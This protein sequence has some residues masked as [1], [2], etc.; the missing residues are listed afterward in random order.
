MKT[1]LTKLKSSF[2][3]FSILA[4]HL[5]WAKPVAQVVEISGQVFAITEDGKTRS[6]KLNEHL[7]EKN[8]VMVEEGS[9]IT[10][11]DY[12]DATYHLIGGSHLKFFD[13]S[14]QLK[15]GKTWIQSKN[16]RHK[17]IVTTANGLIEFNKSEFITTFSHA[18][19]RSQVLVVNGDVEVSNI[20]EKNMKQVVS[21][22]QFTLIDPQVENGVPRYPT[23]VGLTSLNTALAEFKH[24]PA[25]I[26]K[27]D[28]LKASEP[29]RAIA[30]VEESNPSTS[31]KGEI[32]F[33]SSTR[34][35]ASVSEGAAHAYFTKK[36]KKF[37]A[38]QD[39]VP[40][41]F[42]GMLPLKKPTEESERSPASVPINQPIKV[43]K[44]DIPTSEEENEFVE[45]LKKHQTEQP[46]YSKELESL[47]DDLKSY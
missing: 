36:V 2:F 15:K 19:A 41:R 5:L 20:L 8:E 29:S 26:K 32:I 10:L 12:Y 35:P 23:K 7:D 42:Y 14:V 4:S 40:V 39:I 24:L 34:A 18:N 25:E 13:K 11:N 3:I 47:V 46:K 45:S 37:S 31:K 17:L 9:S 6:L 38:K 30:S 28:P 43:K 27:T 44:A 22:G 33:I 16:S 21:A 1:S